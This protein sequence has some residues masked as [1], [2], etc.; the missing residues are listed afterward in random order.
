MPVEAL[1]ESPPTPGRLDLRRKIWQ[2]AWPVLV[3]NLFQTLI[4]ITDALMVGWLGTTSL[5]AMGVA[6][7]IFFT[8]GN[9]LNA[10][11]VATQALVARA[12]GERDPAKAR[13]NAATGL[14]AGMMLGLVFAWAG[15]RGSHWMATFF[16][17]DPEV[18]HGATLFLTVAFLATPFS[19]LATIA[20]AV[21]RGA[22]NTATPMRVSG[23]VNLINIGLNYL[24]IFGHAGAPELGITGAAVA[25]FCAKAVEGI[26]LLALLYHPRAP[27]PLAVSDFGRICR[28]SIARFARV[29]LPAVAEPLVLHS[30]FLL[31]SA[32]V[33]GLGAAAIAAHR[34]AVSIEAL[35]FMPGF[36]FGVACATLVGQAL[37]AR[38]PREAEGSCRETLFMAAGLMTVI[39]L[40]YVAFPRQLA[41]LYGAEPNVTALVIGCLF[42]GALEQPFMA[43]GMV[44]QGALRGAGDT[45]ST[46]YVAAAGVW[47]VRVPFVWL[48][49][50]AG[51]GLTGVWLVAL[52]DWGVRASAYSLLYRRGGWKAV[53]L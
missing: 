1:V 14:A 10:L 4:L 17:D 28:G 52:V 25:T 44:L 15:A 21:L 48:A 12:V 2:L 27:V 34:I 49:V 19:V 6:W 42:I 31:F 26:V 9:L 36:A 24:L 41:G 51:W 38:R 3:Q 47:V 46:V 18:V 40:A 37:G 39:G 16:S 22:G 13:A 29:T 30:G 7:P 23:S 32:M 33:A 43:I 50:R 45:R 35:S 53:R 5:A 20:T 8:A 11:G